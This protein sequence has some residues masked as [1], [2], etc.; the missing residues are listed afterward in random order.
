MKSYVLIYL[1][2][3]LGLS[4]K[5]DDP[6]QPELTKLGKRDY[7]WSIDS[8]EYGNQPG[9]IGLQSIWGCSAT[10]V[11]GANGDAPDVRDC[12]WHYDGTKWSRATEGTPITEFTGNKTVYA[13]WGTARN[14]VWAFGRKINQGVL[15]AFIMHYDGSRWVDV[16]PSHIASIS[17]TLYT[18]HGISG[19]DIWVGGYEYALH[20]DGSQ[21]SSY[22]IADSMIVGSLTNSSRKIYC[23]TYSPWGGDSVFIYSLSDTVFVRKDFD[24]RWQSKFGSGVWATDA[25]LTS[26]SNGVTYASLLETGD[27]DTANWRREFTTPTSFRSEF[28]QSPMNVFAVG[29]WNLIYHYNGSDWRQIFISVPNHNVDPHSDFWGVWTDGNEVFVCDRQNGIV[30]HGR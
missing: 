23:D 12:L 30:Y 20:F 7:V 26:F 10:D 9:R 1:C 3:I 4:C 16:T 19:S 2:L 14:N 21:W 6:A 17:S 25:R 13:V 27:I 22:L 5:K 28:V 15:S 24:E 11:W 8:V 18:V 29:V